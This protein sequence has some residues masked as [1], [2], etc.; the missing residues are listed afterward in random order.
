MIGAITPNLRRVALAMV[1]PGRVRLCFVLEQEDARDREEIDDIAFEFEA[2]QAR[3]I[4]VD[5]E[6]LIDSRRIEEIELPAR[7]IYGRRE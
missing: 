6:V 7:V 2:L 5:V 3:G 4:E 1:G